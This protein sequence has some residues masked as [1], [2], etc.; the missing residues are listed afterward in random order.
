MLEKV[1]KRK[2][3]EKKKKK[4]ANSDQKG[5][6]TFISRILPQVRKADE[7][8]WKTY[9]CTLRQ[10]IL[11]FALPKT[12]AAGGTAEMSFELLKLSI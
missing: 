4:K 8:R 11:S 2:E 6:H 7:N 1:T 10:T 9:S 12:A 3:E 5:D